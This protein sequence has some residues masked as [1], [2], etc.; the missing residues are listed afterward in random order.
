[1]KRE[2]CCHGNTSHHIFSLPPLHAQYDGN[3]GRKTSRKANQ[4]VHRLILINAKINAKK[5]EK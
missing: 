2:S 1:M 5:T 3:A 4:K